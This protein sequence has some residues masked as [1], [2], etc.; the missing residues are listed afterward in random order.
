MG[1]RCF[2]HIS[3][4]TEK[5][6]PSKNVSKTDN[7]ARKLYSD[8]DE[9]RP[10]SNISEL[11]TDHKSVVFIINIEEYIDDA[12]NYEVIILTPDHEVNNND[13]NDMLFLGEKICLSVAYFYQLPIYQ[14]LTGIV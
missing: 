6:K 12:G 2:N 10:L 4:Q 13:F 7:I 8:N 11:F 14:Q 3:C 1:T 5:Q 9:E